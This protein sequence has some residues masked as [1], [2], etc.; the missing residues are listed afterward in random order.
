MDE[1][2]TSGSEFVSLTQTPQFA[3]EYPQ[4][5]VVSSAPLETEVKKKRSPR[6]LLIIIAVFVLVAGVGVGGVYAYKTYFLTPRQ[7]M[8]MAYANLQ[9][10]KAFSY[11]GEIDFNIRLDEAD[12]ITAMLFPT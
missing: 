4:D 3:Q 9:E 7:V 1:Q 10:V 8:S 12:S 6:L 5:I 11:K 2:N